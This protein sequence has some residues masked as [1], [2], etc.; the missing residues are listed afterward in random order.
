MRIS[1]KTGDVMRHGDQARIAVQF[2]EEALDSCWSVDYMLVA[3]EQATIEA[4]LKKQVRMSSE[5]LCRSHT[6]SPNVI[7]ACMSFLR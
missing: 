7:A 2:L 4:A 3:D 1:V 6:H 5:L